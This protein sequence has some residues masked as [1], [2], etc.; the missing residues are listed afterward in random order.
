MKLYEYQGKQIFAEFLIPIP[1]GKVATTVDEVKKIASGA[2]SPVVIKAQVLIGGRGKAGGVKIAKTPEDAEKIAQEILGM[3]IKGLTVNKVLVEETMDIDKEYYLSLVMDRDSKGVTIMASLEGGVEIETVAKETPDKLFKVTV[4]P[5]TDLWGYHSR[6]LAMKMFPGERDKI[7]SFSKILS[8]LY[9]IYIKKD[10][11]LVEINPLI[12][13]KSGQLVAL[14][15]K[16]II[17]DNGVFRQKDLAPFELENIDDLNERKAKENNLSFVKLDGE[18]G[19]C[20]NGAGL[21]MATMDVIKHFGS[22]PANFLDIGGSSNPEKVISALEI[23]TSD[24]N[25]KAILFNIFGGITRCDD[26]A[27]GIKKALEMKPI[28]IP[29]VIRLTGTNDEEGKKILESINLPATTSMVE[30]VK[31]V[32]EVSKSK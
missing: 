25:V 3:S 4:D 14:D 1:K 27:T 9:E 30:A 6:Y 23:I 22:S 7:R 11:T 21:A 32:I 24:K 10:A 26:V 20:V 28:E 15:S 5:L 17:D 2:N 29:L 8:K 18:I 16:I 31:K 13:T 19:C 12:S